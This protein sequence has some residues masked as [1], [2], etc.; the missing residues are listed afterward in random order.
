VVVVVVVVVVAVVVVV[1]VVVVTMI[2]ILVYDANYPT[3]FLNSV[4]T[5][6]LP[7]LTLNLESGA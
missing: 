6:G 2:Y 5:V 3:E 7:Q 1:V 4:D